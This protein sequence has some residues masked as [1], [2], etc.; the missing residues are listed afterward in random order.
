VAFAGVKGGFLRTHGESVELRERVCG[1]PEGPVERL[2]RLL[3]ARR[4]RLALLP[5]HPS[6]SPQVVA[7]RSVRRPPSPARE[8]SPTGHRGETALAP[9]RR[10]DVDAHEAAA[11]RLSLPALCFCFPSPFLSSP[12]PWLVFFS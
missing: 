1:A 12:T 2:V 10:G 4:L 8:G 9:R 3:Q 6:Q 5:G 11:L 7:S